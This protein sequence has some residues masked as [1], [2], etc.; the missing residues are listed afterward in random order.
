MR[1]PLAQ[2][3]ERAA[4]DVLPEPV[5]RYFRQGSADEITADEAVAGWRRYRFL[6]RVLRDVST[7]S[8]AANLLGS[9]VASPI[10]IAPSALQMH[11]HPEGE[12]EMARAAANAQALI[13]V[14]SN[15]G[16]QF[17]SIAAVGAAWW[18]QVYVLRER[19]LTEHLLAQAVAAGASAVVLTVDTPVVAAKDEHDMSVWEVTPAHYLHSN[20]ALPDGVDLDRTKA[21]DLTPATIGWLAERTRLPV[22]VKGVLRPDDAVRAV[23]AG[24]AAVWVSNH[25]GRQLDRTASTADALPAVADAVGDRAEIYVDGGIRDGRDAAVALALG[26][27]AVVFIG[28]PALWG[29]AVGGAD[30]VRD[31]LLALQDELRETM[32]LC[33]VSRLGDF[34]RDVVA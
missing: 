11:A 3:L 12:V 9:G 10:A 13:C 1:P 21:R 2:R 31:L 24:A 6:P 22:V 5:Y 33:G 7:V 25:G 4:A 28:R 19:A 23:A 20:S 34:G 30:Q 18:A 32:V 8:T 14:S 15:A 27:D 17:A 29:L 26:A 16:Q